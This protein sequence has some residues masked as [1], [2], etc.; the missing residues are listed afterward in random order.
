MR[1]FLLLAAVYGAIPFILARPYVGILVWSW[2]G[3]MNPHRLA[4]GTAFD[5]RFSEVIGIATLVGFAI[6][7][8]PKR[9]PLTALTVIWLMLVAWMNVTTFYAL[10]PELAVPHWERVMKI[11]L[12]AFLTLI[13]IRGQLR[14]NQLVWVIV[15]SLGFYGVKGGIFTILTQGEYR[16][17]GPKWS[18]IEENNA[19]ALALIMTIPLMRYLQVEAENRLVRLGLLALMGLTVLSI[20]ASHSR[21]G[22]LAGS[23]MALFLLLKSPHRLRVG[24]AML[25]VIPCI[26]L[27]MPQHWFDR[28][29]TIRTYQEDSSAMGRINAWGFAFNLASDRPLV[30][31]GFNT[32]T[33]ELFKRYAPEPLD[34]HDSHSIYF[35]MLGEHGF[36]GVGLFLLVGILAF[37]TGTWIIRHTREF[38]ELKWA[39]NLAGLLQASLVGY[40][41]G[42]AF[43][44]LAYFD[45]YYH[46]VGLLVLLRAEVQRTLDGK[47]AQPSNIGAPMPAR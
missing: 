38:A 41:V 3:Y 35:E 34:Y 14:I 1:D 25:V 15:L 30:G 4:W 39:R 37:L 33:R 24:L 46:L 5:Y 6:S 27:F 42:G 43:L 31:G 12:F 40:A 47:V 20:F 45:L 36:V 17:F 19:L 23:A 7:R 16:V 44:G 9:I 10:V 2:L 28:M 8:E 26:L 21:G 29:S 22:L 11:Q 18:F 13:L 32:F